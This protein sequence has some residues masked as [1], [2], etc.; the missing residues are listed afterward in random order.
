MDAYEELSIERIEQAK[1][2]FRLDHTA[3]WMRAALAE[4]QVVSTKRLWE[5]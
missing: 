5:G 1:N 4:D 2:C 3:N